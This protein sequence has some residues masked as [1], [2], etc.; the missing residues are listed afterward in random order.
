MV[1]VIG[2]LA[3]ATYMAPLAFLLWPGFLLM[4]Y[5]YRLLGFQGIAFTDYG[6]I[7]WP[8]L[9]IDIA[10]YSMVYFLFRKVVLSKQKS[11]QRQPR[12]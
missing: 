6:W 2:L 7:F 5:I 4:N 8:A 10:L 11:P 1:A 12:G 3:A 9:L